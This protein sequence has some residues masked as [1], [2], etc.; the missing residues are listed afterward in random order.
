MFRRDTS[1]YTAASFDLGGIDENAV[2]TFTDSDT[3]EAFEISGG[4]L[5]KNGFCVTLSEK[6]ASKVYFYT[7]S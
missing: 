2:Y 6:R 7:H 3:D 4:T 1:P 5:A